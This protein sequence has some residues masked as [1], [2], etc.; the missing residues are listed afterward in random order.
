MNLCYGVFMHVTN[1]VKIVI[2]T[3]LPIVVY[4]PEALYSFGIT[5]GYVHHSGST[6]GF[7]FPSGFIRGMCF[8]RDSLEICGYNL[9]TVGRV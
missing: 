2:V 7:M 8:S 1:Y 4:S 5:I 9:P 6:K 3:H